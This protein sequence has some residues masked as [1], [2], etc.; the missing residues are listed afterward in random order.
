MYKDN[1]KRKEIYNEVIREKGT[2]E[3]WIESLEINLSINKITPNSSN[4]DRIIQL[5]NRT[6]QF[7][8]TGNKFNTGLLNEKL[9]EDNLYYYGSVSDRIG[10]EGLISVIGCK[11]DGKNLLI[12][13]YILSCRVFGRYF[14]ELMLLPAFDYAISIKSD[15]YF[16]FV[17]T[18]RNKVI[19]E[20]ISKLTNN[21]HLPLKN[22]VKLHREFSKLPVKVL[23]NF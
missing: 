5:F 17:D 13:N 18:G 3:K 4:K 14:E 1:Q 19:K 22:I 2:K 16:E 15:I 12:E 21:N 10:S 20:F 7:N 8:L 9:V 6:N 11:C 23:N